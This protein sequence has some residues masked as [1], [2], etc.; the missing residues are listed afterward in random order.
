MTA[1][2]DDVGLDILV[3]VAPARIMC[4]RCVKHAG[5]ASHWCIGVAFPE[6]QPPVIC[7]CPC[8]GVNPEGPA[9]RIRQLKSRGRHAR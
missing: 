4:R 5:Q 1:Q 8:R 3:P 6:G 7:Q 2:P 9:H